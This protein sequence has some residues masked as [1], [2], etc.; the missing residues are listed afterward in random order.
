MH[1][2]GFVFLSLSLVAQ[3]FGSSVLSGSHVG[4]PSGDYYG[5]GSG[6][7]ASSSVSHTDLKVFPDGGIDYGGQAQGS[8]TFGKFSLFTF[9]GGS[10]TGFYVTNPTTP[11]FANAGTQLLY[12]DSIMISG[13]T[14]QG[15]LRIP[16]LVDGSVYLSGS[17]RAAF[18]FTFCQ[19]IPTGSPT[20]GVGCA[21]NGLPAFAND[22]PPNDLF[23]SSAPDFSKLYNLDFLFTFGTSYDVNFTVGLS[24][25]ASGAIGS[26]SADFSRTGLE[27]PAQVFDQS[28]NLLPNATIAAQ[29]GFDYANPQSSSIPEPGCLILAGA[30][31][32]LIVGGRAWQ[33]KHLSKQDKAEMVVE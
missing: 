22:Q 10:A 24:S 13:G 30:G 9:A 14:G 1:T 32:V 6:D 23:L 19:S 29:S 18:G 31:L 28:G 12:S 17:G 15:T 11:A 33:T 16:F 26:S 2:H 5:S 7:P 21:V 4:L 8:G 27:Q 3:A 25:G 20:G